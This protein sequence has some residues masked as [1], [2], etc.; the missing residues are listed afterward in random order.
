MIKNCYL[1]SDCIFETQK[2]EKNRTPV[3]PIKQ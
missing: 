1:E 3:N 2:L